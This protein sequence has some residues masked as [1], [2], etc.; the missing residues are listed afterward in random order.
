MICAVADDLLP[1]LT[2]ALVGLRTPGAATHPR[3]G[4]TAGK[5]A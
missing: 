1:R 3:M 5:T 2:S 4:L